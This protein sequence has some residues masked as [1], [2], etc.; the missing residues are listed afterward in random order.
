MLVCGCGNCVYCNWLNAFIWVLFYLF[1]NV[2]LKKIQKTHCWHTNIP[3]K[4]II[5]THL[6]KHPPIQ[7]WLGLRDY[8]GQ[9][10]FHL[11]LRFA[12]SVVVWFCFIQDA[13]GDIEW[14]HFSW[15]CV[16]VLASWFNNIA[17]LNDTIFPERFGHKW[18]QI[19]VLY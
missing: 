4:T 1:Y 12:I 8:F 6:A 9:C 5:A 7:R 2:Q 19:S 14:Q 15:M 11:M 18:K 3:L 13:A 17:S 10:V 16:L